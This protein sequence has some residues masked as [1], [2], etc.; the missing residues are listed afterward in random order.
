MGRPK[1]LT[2][3]QRSELRAQG[4]RPV[5]MWVPDWDSPLFAAA[6]EEECRLIRDSDRRTGMNETLDAFLQDVW[7]D[8]R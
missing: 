2:E 1:E 5:E 4:L 6:I 3:E 7:D 8:F